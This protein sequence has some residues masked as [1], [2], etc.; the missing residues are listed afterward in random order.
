MSELADTVREALRALADSDRSLKRFGAAAHRYELEPPAG[1]STGH[2]LPKDLLEF[3][4]TIGSAGAGPGYG[5]L[6]IDDVVEAATPWRKGV[7]AAH[8]GCGYTAIVAMPSGEVWID[9]RAVGVAKPI[10]PSFTAWYLDW[11]DRL[12]HNTLPEAHVP[13]GACPLPN[14]LSGFLGIRERQLG[15]DEGSLAGPALRDALGELGPHSIEIAAESSALFRNGTR[16]DPCVACARLIENLG[17]D[18]LRPDV[19]RSAL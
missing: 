18:G 14:A 9:A 6:G 3:V 16:V 2:D 15:L 11:I 13:A 7:I 4:L 5:F 8:L 19:V 1:L 12:A 10:A 17:A